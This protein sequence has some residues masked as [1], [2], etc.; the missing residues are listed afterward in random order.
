ME[1]SINDVLENIRA[2]RDQNQLQEL[3]KSEETQSQSLLTLK[4]EEFKTLRKEDIL[5]IFL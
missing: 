1:A 3:V 4:L 5:S 2:H